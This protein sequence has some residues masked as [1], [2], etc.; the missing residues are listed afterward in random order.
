MPRWLHSGRRR[1]ICII[2]Y[3]TD[4][5]LA[6]EIKTQLE[7]HYGTR[8]EPKQFRQTLSKLVDTD[9]VQAT[10]DGLQDRYTLTDAGRRALEAHVTFIE[11]HV[12]Q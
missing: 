12:G 7:D 2:L 11:E 3:D 1:D 9:Y 8:I 10:P 6:Q 5:L 4:G